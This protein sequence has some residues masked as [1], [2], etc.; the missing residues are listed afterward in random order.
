MFAVVAKGGRSGYRL[1]SVPTLG[2]DVEARRLKQREE[3][4]V[5]GGKNSRWEREQGG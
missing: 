2:D 5:G 3:D 1:G 4:P